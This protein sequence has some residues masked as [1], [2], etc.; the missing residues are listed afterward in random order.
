MFK[1]RVTNSSIVTLKAPRNRQ[2]KVPRIISLRSLLRLGL[3]EKIIESFVRV[4]Y[5]CGEIE[6]L[7]T[8]LLDEKK[9]LA[10]MFKELYNLSKVLKVFLVL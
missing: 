1:Q 3:P 2:E 10:L 6:V 5:R 9:Y 4:R 7:V 8:S